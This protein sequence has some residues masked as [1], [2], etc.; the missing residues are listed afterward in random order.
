MEHRNELPR[1]GGPLTAWPDPSGPLEKLLDL[2][3]EVLERVAAHEDPLQTLEALCRLT[4][5]LLPDS[6]AS[7][8]V[9]DD[10][11]RLKVCAA[12]SIP[13]G[14]VRLLDGL[15]PGPRAG[16][17]G[18]AVHRGEPV[19]VEDARSDLRWAPL[20][21]IVRAV[22]LRA[23][24]SMPI[25]ARDVGIL[26]SFALTSF[27]ARAPSPFHRRLLGIAADL[28]G[29]VLRRQ[30]LEQRLLL[31]ST[32]FEHMDEGVMITDARQRIVEVNQAFTR[33]TGYEANEAIGQTPRILRSGHHS[34]AFY[35]AF[36]EELE[37]TGQWR[38]EVWNR[39]KNGEIY[40]QLLSV[41][42]VHD[43]HG[44]LTH[45]V[46][47]FSDASHIKSSEKRLWELAHHDELTGLPNR[48]F[49]RESLDRAVERTKRRG[50]RLAVLFLDLDRFK[51]V[52][53]S[54][55]HHAGDS[56]LK[57]AA[58]RL[59]RCLR[60]AD[61]VARLGGDEFVVLVDPCHEAEA[62]EGVARKILEAFRLPFELEGQ[63]FVT[64]TSIGISHY[65]DHGT[66]GAT[67]LQHADAAMYEAKKHGRNRAES[68][69]PRMT[70]T[71]CTRIAMEAE[72]RQALERGQFVLHYQPIY[73]ARNLR[74]VGMEALVRWQHPSR[75]LIPP[76][77]FI[78]LAEEIGLIHELGYW[79]TETA[80]RQGAAWRAAGLGDFVLCVNVS[81]SQIQ[82]G[83]AGKLQSLLEH[84]GFPAAR[85]E[86]EI[87][88]SLIMEHGSAAGGDL[89]AIRE[90][91]VRLAMD[92]FGT[93]FSSMAQ[94][95][96][97]PIDTLKI[98]RSFIRDLPENPSVAAIV[99][100]IVALGHALQLT[101]TAEGVE[102]AEQ[103]DFLRRHGCDF[104]QGY[105]FA[106]PQPPEAIAP[107][108]AAGGGH[109]ATA[110]RAADGSDD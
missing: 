3:H 26:G 69:Q 46:A 8:M 100:A 96:N 61:L 47:I 90:T 102:H 53:D 45:Y 39:R 88:E 18:T 23:C 43:E 62:A 19:F 49:F 44:E 48:V 32:A 63:C 104:L 36:W 6:V 93:G 33:I 57:Q 99:E 5:K 78:P 89:R 41:K 68:Y 81:P 64:T 28:A 17:C 67:L 58:E 77:A 34:P 107:L 85:L 55:G 60:S 15:R 29:I 94:L 80:C 40:P 103:E 73:D 12:P 7:V 98:D 86:L 21:H 22:H 25:R 38:G 27:T 14:V 79:V 72:L 66:D 1:I 105:R 2:Q 91:G 13:P 65:P 51:N 70:A 101:V 82:G 11:G 76:A 108:F 87:T 24:W 52:N 56:L 75:G 59:R 110:D 95:K 20:R 54:L 97:L 16:S 83:C 74:P 31:A 35:R 92:D 4:E 50:G 37:R 71:V 42:A 30:R 109:P 84:T 9:L 10:T 106:R